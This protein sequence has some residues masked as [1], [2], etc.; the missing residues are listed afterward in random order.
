[1]TN[2]TG[3]YLHIPF[4][5]KKCRYCDFYSSFVTEELLDNYTNAL[6]KSIHQ[7]GGGLNGRPIDTIYL[8][9][10]TP[11]LLQHRL[12]LLLTEIKNSFNVS[13]DCETTLELNPATNSKRL[14]EYAIKAEV[15]RLSIGA[16]SG[17]DEMLSLLGRT[18]SANDTQNT[19]ALAREMGFSNISLDIMI[20]LPDSSADSLKYDLEFISSLSPDHISAYILKIEE[21]TAFFAR[22]DN[23]NLPDDDAQAEQYLL[24]C[25]FFESKGFEHYEISNFAKNGKKSRHNL[26]Y[27]IGHDYLGIG[28]AAHSM[29][30][31]KR[32]YYPRDLK[33]FI[34]GNT[35]LPDGNGGGKEEYIMLRLRLKSGI[36]YEEYKSLFGA[37]LSAEF[38]EKCRFY[39]KAGLMDLTDKKIALTNKGMLLSNSIITELLECE[40]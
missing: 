16:Q 27:W 3:L 23:L 38:L 24:M 5:E 1:M 13:R 34:N 6:I 21:N 2:P 20:G 10:G 7:W 36:V 28:P 32:F 40:I 25:D 31:S 39:A 35:P 14:L 9:G 19:V 29:L 15:T 12:P 33:S 11:S 8:G 18:H 26:K 30:D 4:C 17:S 22:K 37:E